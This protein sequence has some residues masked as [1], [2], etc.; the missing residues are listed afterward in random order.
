VNKFAK[1]TRCV[2]IPNFSPIDKLI[3]FKRIEL[4]HGPFVALKVAFCNVN[5]P[6]PTHSAIWESMCSPRQEPILVDVGDEKYHK[7]FLS[8]SQMQKMSSGIEG[9]STWNYLVELANENNQTGALKQA[10]YSV[11]KIIRDA[12]HVVKAQEVI[13]WK[14]MDVVNSFFWKSAKRNRG[15]LFEEPAYSTLHQLWDGFNV[16]EAEVLPFTLPMY[17]RKLFVSGRPEAEIIAKISW[18]LDVSKQADERR[19]AG[20]KK[21]FK[22]RPFRVGNDHPAGLA[23]VDGYFESLGFIYQWPGSG[24][25]W[26]A[27][28]RDNAGHATIMPSVRHPGAD[29]T[30][31]AETLEGLE[32]TRWYHEKRFSS[33]Q[34]VMNGSFQFTGVTPTSLSDDTLIRVV[35]DSLG[36]SSSEPTRP[37]Y[38]GRL[39][40]SEE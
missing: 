7:G 39:V 28:V 40:R 36:S 19:T 5:I 22:F 29:F 26:L 20:R 11:A 14:G 24:K 37:V 9:S 21:D 31:L 27:I 25:L 35:R 38:S 2:V 18:W 10:R 8:A 12:Y 16:R 33:G 15:L 13:F 17:F 30:K 6:T 34:M 1:P 32:P 23:H 3:A 4:D